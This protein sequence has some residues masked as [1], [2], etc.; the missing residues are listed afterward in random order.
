MKNIWTIFGRE[1]I[2]DIFW[3]T[4]LVGMGLRI[5]RDLRNVRIL[6][7]YYAH[8]KFQKYLFLRFYSFIGIAKN[9]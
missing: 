8:P 5:R 9:V 7:L 2:L 6:H 4:F 3:T 1:N